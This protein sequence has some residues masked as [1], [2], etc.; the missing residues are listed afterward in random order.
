MYTSLIHHEGGGP[1]FSARLSTGTGFPNAWLAV[2]FTIVPGYQIETLFQVYQLSPSK[3]CTQ[4]LYGGQCG[5]GGRYI[6]TDKM[7]V[8]HISCGRNSQPCARFS[9]GSSVPKN[10]YLPIIRVRFGVVIG[11]IVYT[12]LPL[13]FPPTIL[14]F[15]THFCTVKRKPCSYLTN[16]VI[17]VFRSNHTS[18]L[19][20]GPNHTSYL[21][22]NPNHT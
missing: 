4:S 11:L 6:I 14:N 3:P 9:I 22:S 1:S 18:Y 19:I 5:A 13:P 2:D 10:P 7:T 17:K 15:W 8:L 12:L 21:F 20:F 16:M